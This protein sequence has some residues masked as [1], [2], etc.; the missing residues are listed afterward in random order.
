M[1]EQPQE[2]IEEKVDVGGVEM[3]TTK[4]ICERLSISLQTF[5]RLRKQH[6]IPVHILGRRSHRYDPREVMI[7]VDKLRSTERGR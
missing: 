4:Q 7:A 1:A 6:S 3:L 2:A 5:R